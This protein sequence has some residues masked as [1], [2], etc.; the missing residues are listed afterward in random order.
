M[1]DLEDTLRC[2]DS[3]TRISLT[4]RTLSAPV[5]RSGHMSEK[6][7]LEK[8][9]AE[10]LDQRIFD[11]RVRLKAYS[12]AVALEDDSLKQQRALLEETKRQ[13]H[14]LL[15]LRHLANSKLVKRACSHEGDPLIRDC[16]R[17]RSKLG[18]QVAHLSQQF[19]DLRGIVK[20]KLRTFH[21]M[22]RETQQLWEEVKSQK[23]KQRAGSTDSE[24]RLRKE[25]R[26]LKFMISD[27]LAG[28][29]IDWC[30]DPR[31]LQ[32]VC[33]HDRPDC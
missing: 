25:N 7:H 27:L 6:L 8:E 2:C 24:S 13:Q 15:V 1:D 17:V 31:L 9:L 10:W 18:K 16:L 26:L 11:Y 21:Q 28:S 5:P 23:E 22:E 4:Y 3:I 20:E 33:P 32:F 19:N 12:N 14:D 30:E 29:K